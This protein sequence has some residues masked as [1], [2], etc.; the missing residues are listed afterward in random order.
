MM[1]ESYERDRWIDKVSIARECRGFVQGVWFVLATRE[2]PDVSYGWQTDT[3]LEQYDQLDA[4]GRVGARTAPLFVG[5]ALAAFAAHLPLRWPTGWVWLPTAYLIGLW[6]V[7]TFYD[8]VAGFWR[9][10]FD[11][12][13]PGVASP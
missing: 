1:R 13:I 3:C 7:F 2:T 11:G 10:I 9:G 6:A 4:V 12:R 8:V 5:L